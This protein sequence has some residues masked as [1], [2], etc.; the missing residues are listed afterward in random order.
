M[1]TT[2]RKKF[3]SIWTI[4]NRISLSKICRIVA[5]FGRLSFTKTKRL[6]WWIPSIYN[7]EQK[8]S[9]TSGQLAIEFHCPETFSSS[10][11]TCR[12][13]ANSDRLSF[14]NWWP[15]T[16]FFFMKKKHPSHFNWRKKLS[17]L[18]T[19]LLFFWTEQ[20]FFS[21]APEVNFLPHQCQKLNMKKAHLRWKAWHPWEM[22]DNI[23]FIIYYYSIPCE[24]IIAE[25]PFNFTPSHWL[26]SGG[27]WCPHQ[28]YLPRLEVDHIV[29]DLWR[30]SV[31]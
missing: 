9:S 29:K 16:Y 3:I 15:W 12:I 6:Q 10:L 17:N 1:T 23:S 31:Y 11:K 28:Y 7:D 2:N 4:G 8:I 21:P 26:W 22:W 27:S 25:R 5:N 20:G 14:I 19:F 30:I 24:I 18:E 13:L